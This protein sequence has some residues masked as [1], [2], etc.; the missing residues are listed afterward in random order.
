MT[1]EGRA[2]LEEALQESAR[3]AGL[4]LKDGVG[5]VVRSDE[6]GWV[7]IGYHWQSGAGEVTSAA[8]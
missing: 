2:F 8:E 1:R 5:T 4:E 7:T 6:K 3:E